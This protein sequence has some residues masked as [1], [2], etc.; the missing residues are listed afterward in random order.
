[1]L[2][3]IQFRDEYQ[4]VAIKQRC[5]DQKKQPGPRR[6]Q[7]HNRKISAGLARHDRER[8]AHEQYPPQ[9]VN[10][11]KVLTLKHGDATEMDGFACI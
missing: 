9:Q 5:I 6:L 4:Q 8:Q 1:M 7:H 10:D 3:Q 2:F 11:P